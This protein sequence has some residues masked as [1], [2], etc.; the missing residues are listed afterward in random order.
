VVLHTH[1]YLKAYLERAAAQPEHDLPEHL[2]RGNEV[3]HDCD[4]EVE[5]ALPKAAGGLSGCDEQ[6]RWD[7]I[8]CEETNAVQ[9]EEYAGQ[10]LEDETEMV[11]DEARRSVEAKKADYRPSLDSDRRRRHRDPWGRNM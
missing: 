1:G 5:E 2:D 7:L 10:S 11:N 9:I 3:A 8:P 6:D 4:T